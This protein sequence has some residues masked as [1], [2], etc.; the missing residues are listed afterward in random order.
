[1]SVLKHE[2]YEVGSCSLVFAM[3]RA[4][5]PVFLN[6]FR[7]TLLLFCWGVVT[8]V[9]C[10]CAA[11]VCMALHS[12]LLLPLWKPVMAF[13]SVLKNTADIPV[14]CG[15]R[16]GTKGIEKRRRGEDQDE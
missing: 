15:T 7:T 2:C 10:F 12:L 16:R 8:A 14:L 4:L 13:S 5:P 6:I 1:M 3:S 11:G 9:G